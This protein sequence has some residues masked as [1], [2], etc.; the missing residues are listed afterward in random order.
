MIDL[1]QRS[2]S[3]HGGVAEIGIHHG[4]FFLMLN[5][6]CDADELSY[7]IDLF[8][9]Q[10]LNIDF[11]GAGN[12]KIFEANLAKF[13]RHGGRNVRI[14]AADSTTTKLPAQI[15]H[16]VRIFSVDGGHTV[17]HTLNDLAVASK[18]IAD[19]GVVI[20]DDIL[21]AH[22][23]G[24]IEGALRFLWRR[25][26]LLPFAIG[27]N[28]LFLAQLSHRKRYLDRFSASGFCKKRDVEFGGYTLVAI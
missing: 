16:E 18:A 15:D 10:E 26:T 25:P 12:R 2:H 17:E 11:S 28:K 7:A 23:L 8:D 14:I 24:V 27:H 22:W 21:N 9:Q 19:G 6:V 1:H 3:V 20:L 5:A 13:D 4:K